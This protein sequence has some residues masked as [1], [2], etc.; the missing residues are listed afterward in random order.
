MAVLAIVSDL[1]FASKIRE[2]AQHAGVAVDFATSA[3][4]I[5]E[6]AAGQPSL[7]IVDL[8]FHNINPLSLIDQLR[9]QPDLG[10]TKI[11]GFGSH[12]QT[13]LL[14]QARQAGCHV[15]LPRSAFSQ[16]LVKILQQG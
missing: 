12:V 10:G 15:V 6:L 4:R 14:E 3:P 9:R 13:D 5:I 8:N 1:I 7:V 2:S 11:L 16:N